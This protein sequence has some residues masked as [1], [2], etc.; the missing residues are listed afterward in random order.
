M[1]LFCLVPHL[2]TAVP[3]SY[4]KSEGLNVLLPVEGLTKNA[5]TEMVHVC[6]PKAIIRQSQRMFFSDKAEGIGK[7][8]F[9]ALILD[10]S[11]SQASH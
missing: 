5:H 6:L 10:L 4:L 1:T 7:V 9:L 8:N 3:V 2:A 11:L